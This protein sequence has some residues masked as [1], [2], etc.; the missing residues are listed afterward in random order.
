MTDAYFEHIVDAREICSNCHRKNRVE[1]VDP[2]MSRSGLRHELDSHYSRDER[3]TTVDYHDSDPEPT[4]AKGV[5]CGCG[6]EGSH[7]RIWEP[8]AI[9]RERFKQ[10]L[11]NTVRSLEERGVSI[12]RK[13]MV[14]VAL[15]HFD[16]HGDVDRALATG[17]DAGIVA[18]TATAD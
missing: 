17:T 2:V 3:R 13:E 14:A 18:A 6:V 4:H 1:R 10:L 11:Q 16:D 15:S 12:K 5:F 8:T 9:D 7:D